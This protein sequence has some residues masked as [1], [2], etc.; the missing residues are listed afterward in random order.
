M[1]I[2]QLDQTRLALIRDALDIVSPL[3]EEEQE[4]LDQLRRLF[5]GLANHDCVVTLSYRMGDEP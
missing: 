3:E 4:A 2:M 5:D 1:V